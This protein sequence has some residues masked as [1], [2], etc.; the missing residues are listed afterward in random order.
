MGRSS[1]IIPA[2]GHSG[3][4]L[5]SLV[6][7]M[8]PIIYGDFQFNRH[9]FVCY[10]V[11]FSSSNCLLWTLQSLFHGDDLN[12]HSIQEVVQCSIYI[13]V[14]AVYGYCLWSVYDMFG[15]KIYGPVFTFIFSKTIM[16]MFFSISSSI[17]EVILRD[18]MLCILKS[19][20]EDVSHMVS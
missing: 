16:C 5:V 17:Y 18:T 11:H 10:L 3:M 12:E 2:I 7:N 14:L 13:I 9:L 8:K 6:M 20:N 1:I 15:R 4:Y 19:F